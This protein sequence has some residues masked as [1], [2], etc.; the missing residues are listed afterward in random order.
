MSVSRTWRVSVVTL[1]LAGSPLATGVAGTYL[2]DVDSAATLLDHAR[3][4][5][6]L[7][8]GERG[9]WIQAVDLHWFYAR[10]AHACRGLGAT[11]SLSFDTRGSDNIDSRSAVVVPGGGRCA[12]LSLLPNQGPPKNRNAG[13]APQPQAQ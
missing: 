12:L 7:A 9:L 13:V 10:F 11:S 6:W 2:E 4:H 8:D 5:D 1:V 3:L